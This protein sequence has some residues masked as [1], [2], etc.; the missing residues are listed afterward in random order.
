MT[1]T[2]R[3]AILREGCRVSFGKAKGGLVYRKLACDPVMPLNIE[4]DV[5]NDLDREKSSPAF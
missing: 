4:S 3:A 5:E 1:G 2:S